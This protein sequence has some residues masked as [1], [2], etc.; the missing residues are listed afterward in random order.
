MTSVNISL[1][2]CPADDDCWDS[3]SE[4]D[5]SCNHTDSTV[6]QSHSHWR[7]GLN[8]RRR[9]HSNNPTIDRCYCCCLDCERKT[10]EFHWVVIF[11]FFGVVLLKDEEGWIIVKAFPSPRVPPSSIKNLDSQLVF[12]KRKKW[13]F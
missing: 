8:F 2:F 4:F 5:Q 3:Q 11:F 10:R 12:R 7:G 13:F 1:S 6:Y 9:Y